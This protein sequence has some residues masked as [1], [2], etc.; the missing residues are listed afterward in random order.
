MWLSCVVMCENTSDELIPLGFRLG[1]FG[2]DLQALISLIAYNGISSRSSLFNTN[3]LVYIF[4]W[5]AWIQ[6]KSLWS[7]SD[8]ILLHQ[9]G[10]LLKMRESR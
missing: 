3:G 5:R 10:G 4:E 8:S 2:T 9:Q 7:F 6:V 1:P